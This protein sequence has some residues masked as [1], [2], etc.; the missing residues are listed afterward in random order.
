MC[1]VGYLPELYQ[2]ARSEKYK[3]TGFGFVVTMAQQPSPPQWVTAS[4]FTRFLDHTHSD[5]P[6]AEGLLWT[7]DQVDAETST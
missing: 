3:I 2:D 4:S 6:H 1:Q 5:T 7:S